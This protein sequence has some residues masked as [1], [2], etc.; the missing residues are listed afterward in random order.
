MRGDLLVA[1]TGWQW[2]SDDGGDLTMTGIWWLQSSRDL[3]M[4]RY[5]GGDL[6]VAGDQMETG[7]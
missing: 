4:G 5:G 3:M 6:M 7:I 2:G 1:G